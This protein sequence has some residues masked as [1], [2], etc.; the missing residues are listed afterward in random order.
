MLLCCHGPQQQR[1]Q[2]DVSKMML[3]SHQCPVQGLNTLPAVPS[4]VLPHHVPPCSVNSKSQDQIAR[5]AARGCK[6]LAGF[7]LWMHAHASGAVVM[8][9]C[10]FIHGG[11]CVGWLSH[12]WLCRCSSMP[13]LQVSAWQR[14]NSR[15]PS[16][17]SSYTRR[18]QET[19]WST[20]KESRMQ[21][22]CCE[23]RERCLPN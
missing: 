20:A 2:V 6:T 7:V 5:L 15:S 4:D 22:H 3:N 12:V 17:H 11:V 18:L 10:A 14:V 1:L 16:A 23:L 9:L 8:Q 13:L 21:Q 19:V